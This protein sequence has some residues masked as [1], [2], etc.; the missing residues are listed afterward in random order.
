MIPALFDESGLAAIHPAR[1]ADVFARLQAATVRAEVREVEVQ[2]A[3]ARRMGPQV[4]GIARIPIT[5]VISK[6]ASLWSELFGDTTLHGLSAALAAAAADA[7]VR[8]V[9]LEV[10]SPGG[11]VYG[12][13]ETAA[14]IAE[15][16]KTKPVVAFADGLAASAA[17]WLI[18][19]AS[20]IVASPSSEIGSIGVYAVHFDQS[21][22]LDKAGVVATLI[23]AGKFK[24]EANPYQ[25]LSQED[26]DAMQARI[27]SHYQRFVS[28]VARGRGIGVDTVRH[29]YGEG[30]VLDAA[31][32]AKVGMVTEIGTWADAVR[33]AL[34]ESRERN[35]P[36]P[37]RAVASDA[38]LRLQLQL[39]E[40]A[41]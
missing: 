39:E 30:R 13:D 1:L 35:K 4:D 25:P 11:G 15:L 8:A 16:N 9:V 10:D 14:Q 18:S 5:G 37:A 32:A 29:D 27:D 26:H 3:A 21:G 20:A 19:Q 7:S 23:K 36:Q 24:A 40:A 12:V 17:Y 31:A 34:S 38:A 22:L 33:V 2:A 28:R 6:N 41:S